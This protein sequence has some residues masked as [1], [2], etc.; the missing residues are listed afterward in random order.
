MLQSIYEFLYN[1]R[2]S[3]KKLAKQ[4][5]EGILFQDESAAGLW[6][7]LPSIHIVLFLDFDGVI[8]KCQNE[9][10]EQMYLIERLLDA[11]PSMFIVISSSWRECA[12]ISYLKSLFRSPYRDR[13][14][15]ATPSLSLPSGNIGV[16]A[17]ECEYFATRYQ[18]NAFICLDDDLTLFPSGYP[19]L[20]PTDY[21]TGVNEK[22]I[23]DLIARYNLIMTRI[24]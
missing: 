19:H 20:F 13:V 24:Y 3:P 15:G 17:A 22:D 10:F 23:V 6:M 9:S 5:V 12:S 18:V 16:R 4:S 1:L 8:H 2:C 11:C 21:Y 14:I 7:P